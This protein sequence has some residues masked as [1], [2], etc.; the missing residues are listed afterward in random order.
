MLLYLKG[1]FMR[2]KLLAQIETYRDYAVE[3][4]ADLTAIPALG[5][6][7]NGTGEMEKALYLTKILENLGLTIERADAPDERVPGGLRPNILAWRPGG[8]G[9][10]CYVLTHMDVVPEGSLSLWDSDP[11]RL[12]VEGSKLYGRGTSDNHDAMVASLLALKAIMELDA[13]LPGPAG[14]SLVSDEETG[15]LMGL[16]YVLKAR[17][18]FFKKEDIIIVPDSGNS[19]GTFIEIAEKSILWLRVEVTGKQAHASVPQMGR[20]ALYAAARMMTAI[21]EVR[22]SLGMH[23]QLFRPPITTMEPTRKE[24]GVSNINTIPGSDVFYI[25]C[26]VLP[27]TPLAELEAGLTSAFDAI[28]AELGV[29]YS[30]TREQALQ[31]PPATAPDAPVVEA[32][33]GAIYQV[34]GQEAHVGGIGG[35]TVAAFFRQRGLSAAVWNTNHCNAHTP[36]EWADIN[37]IINDAKVFALI[38]AGLH[39]PA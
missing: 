5:P 11:W 7:N 29:C 9:P 10:G 34:N 20:N 12:K 28:A 3:L 8:K 23:N 30:M 13:P 1:M 6:T 25:D 38:Y 27:E 36:N 17:P 16:D 37:D 31:A 35:G 26:R 22:D 24:A 14:V 4:M 2:Q 33:K 32:L 19:K 18:D 21:Y 15:S 39:R